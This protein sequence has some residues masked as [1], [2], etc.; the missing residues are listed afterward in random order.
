MPVRPISPQIGN[1]RKRRTQLTLEEMMRQEAARR[2]MLSRFS[3]S[4]ASRGS[5]RSTNPIRGQG[6][7]AFSGGFPN[8][9]GAPAP[10]L[11]PHGPGA[12][13]NARMPWDELPG[14]GPGNVPPPRVGPPAGL[15][16]QLGSPAPLPGG[17]PTQQSQPSQ[18]SN[19]PSELTSWQQGGPSSPISFGNLVP[20]GGGLWLNLDTG[21]IQG[22]GSG[23]IAGNLF[24][25]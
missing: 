15:P 3:R 12:N 14:N 6:V 17:L 13:P 23:G 25:E 24:A 19:L 9:L 2:A 10:A 5:A 18:F 4:G 16:T 1:E 21:S 11:Q 22:G 8:R 20:L 7:R